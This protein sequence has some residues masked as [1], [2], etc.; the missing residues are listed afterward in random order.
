V[1]AL[2][3]L[4]ALVGVIALLAVVFHTG[5]GGS[6]L[7]LGGAGT[8]TPHTVN[9]D[10]DRLYRW[11]LFYFNRDDPALFV[12]KRFGIGWTVNMARPLAWVML[13][14]TVA[15]IAIGPLTH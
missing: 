8:N 4:P 7:R 12:P 15:A 2:A 3:P 10:D 14:A 9:R 13:A 5:Q 1:V 6:R 11:G